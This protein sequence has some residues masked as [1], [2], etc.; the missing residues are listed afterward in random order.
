[1]T[2]YREDSTRRGPNIYSFRLEP[3]PSRD[4]IRYLEENG[5]EHGYLVYKKKEKFTRRDMLK[6]V[7][8]DQNG[9][10]ESKG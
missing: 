1:M 9:K 6:E 8:K 2:A 7:R 5:F 10:S 3:I 4:E